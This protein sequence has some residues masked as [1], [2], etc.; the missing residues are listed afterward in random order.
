MAATDAKIRE[1]M[2]D[3]ATGSLLAWKIWGEWE[4]RD[5][6]KQPDPGLSVA[7][8]LAAYSE[9]CAKTEEFGNIGEFEGV[10]R[11]VISFA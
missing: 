2:P 3:N 8:N 11:L 9:W 6:L 1:M 5:H 4:D 7:M 10:P